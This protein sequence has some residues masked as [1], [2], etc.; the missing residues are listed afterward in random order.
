MLRSVKELL[1]YAIRATDGEIGQ[2]H[3]LYIDD[4][5]WLVRYLVVDAGHRLSGRRVL[6]STECLG[7]PDG[8]HPVLPVALTK[9]QVEHSPHVDTDKPVSRQKEG[10]L[11]RYYG[12][13]PYWETSDPLLGAGG[14]IGW[15]PLK[16]QDSDA[17]QGDSRLRSDRE[18]MRYH[19][20]AVEGLAGQVDDFVVSSESWGIRY[21]IADTGG[22]LPG[23]KVQIAPQWVGKVNWAERK[24]HVALAQ[25]TV[26]H[27]AEFD[28]N[29][30]SSQH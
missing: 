25:E 22:W 5:T 12:W 7:R 14:A 13:I 18:V 29:A 4:Q 19:I 10:E 17:P 27:C 9:C 21:I 15:A 28:P 1:C 8:E 24:I 16:E 6:L 23:K 26:K 30:L 3:D 2:V 11:A 20:Q